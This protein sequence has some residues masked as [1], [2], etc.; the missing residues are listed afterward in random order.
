[1]DN[2]ISTV[3][4]DLA[5]LPRW[6]VWRMEGG[7]KI[8]YRVDGG[9]ASS[10]N[11]QHWGEIGCARRARV[12]GAFSGLAFVFFK[13]DGLVG[14]DL[15][16]SLDT[17]GNLKPPFRGMVERFGDTY[18]ELSP[19][20]RGLK[21]WVRGTLPAN[22]PKVAVESGGVEMYDHARYF[23]FTGR[24]FRGAPLQVEDHAADVLYL[25]EHLT[26][27]RKKTWPLQPLQGGRIPYGQQHSTLVSIAGTLR[28][29]RVCEGAIEACLQV[30]NEKQCERPGPAANISRIVRSTRR[31]TGGAA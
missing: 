11:P 17:D 28:A 8:P 30:M 2:P 23:T 6:A 15:D 18:I 31:W 5:E 9:R 26:K 10:T 24:R 14:I 3:P 4:S 27:A 29:R 7:A 13:E 19:S 20:D 21:M 22:L 12:S 25:Y 16:D 1:V